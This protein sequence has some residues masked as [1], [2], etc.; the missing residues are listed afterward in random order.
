MDNHN[1]LT[2][3]LV[4]IEDEIEAETAKIKDELYGLV[5]EMDESD[6]WKLFHSTSND[7]DLKFGIWKI[8]K[9]R[10]R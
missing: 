6:F 2:D 7:S 4:R 8:N 10:V 9:D 3:E 1:K 5:I